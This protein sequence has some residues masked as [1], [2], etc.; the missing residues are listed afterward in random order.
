MRDSCFYTFFS[1][2]QS[3]HG[4][5]L[6]CL[7]LAY[8]P[9]RSGATVVRAVVRIL[10]QR[11]HD[12][13]RIIAA[14]PPP[15]IPAGSRAG[16]CHGPVPPPIQDKETRAPVASTTPTQYRGT[17][18]TNTRLST[19]QGGVCGAEERTSPPDAL[20][21]YIYAHVHAAPILASSHTHTHT[22]TRPV[23]RS[24]RHP[25]AARRA[26]RDITSACS[27]PPCAGGGPCA[28]PCPCRCRRP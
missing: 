22:P 23:G 20:A 4:S 15:A 14:G 2:S 24:A 12:K 11:T 25:T 6:Y 16:A 5:R 13:S 21:L 7:I 3:G 27:C 10:T 9:P 28:S 26:R 17:H 19:P 8:S 1:A 18:A